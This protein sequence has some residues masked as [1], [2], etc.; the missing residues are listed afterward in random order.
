ML[1][2]LSGVVSKLPSKQG[3]QSVLFKKEAVL[4]E[5]N[6]LKR[7]RKKYQQFDDPIKILALSK[8]TKSI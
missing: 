7:V 5:S 8:H 6:T 2:L 1:L 4:Y 3:D